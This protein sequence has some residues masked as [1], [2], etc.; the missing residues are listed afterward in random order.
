MRTEA[1]IQADAKPGSPFSNG[2]EGYAWMG[3]WCE[4]CTNNDEETELWCPLLTVAL[5]GKTPVEWIEQPWRSWNDANGV[6]HPPAPSL[7][8]KYH[9]IEF[10]DRRDPDD[11][12]DPEPE[13][14]PPVCEGQLDIV[15]LY[16]DAAI[17][18]LT[19]APEVRSV[20]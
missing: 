13:P 7:G 4:R 19:T 10:E 14:E 8:D 5:L 6:E 12:D 15:D 18:Q 11:G 1:E 20:I 16:L 2:T 3:N 17:D 9:C